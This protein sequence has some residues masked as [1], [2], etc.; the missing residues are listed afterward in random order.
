MEAEAIRE[1][2]QARRT[3]QRRRQHVQRERLHVS[4]ASGDRDFPV[5]NLD[6]ITPFDEIITLDD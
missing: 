2:K 6:D 5:D 4:P 1:T 3:A